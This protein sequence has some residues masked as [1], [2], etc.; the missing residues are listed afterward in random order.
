MARQPSTKPG[1]NDRVLKN[2]C[3]QCNHN[4]MFES[5]GMTSPTYKRKC[6]KCGY[7]E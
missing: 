1:G 7:K 4:R 5:R 6:C 3:P 2:N